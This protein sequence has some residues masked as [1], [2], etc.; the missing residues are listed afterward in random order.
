M[1]TPPNETLRI[2]ITHGVSGY[3][4]V[5]LWTNKEDLPQ[6]FTEP[7]DTGIGRYKNSKDAAR[8]ALEWARLENLPIDFN[9]ADYG[10]E[11]TAKKL[12]IR[13]YVGV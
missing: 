9:P 5:L 11:E 10:L 3:F 1:S 7:Y 6:P 13:R 4:A 12:R 8:E 2:A